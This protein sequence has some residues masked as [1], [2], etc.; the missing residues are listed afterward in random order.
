MDKTTKTKKDSTAAPKTIS[1][2][3]TTTTKPTLVPKSKTLDERSSNSARR[4]YRTREEQRTTSRAVQSGETLETIDSALKLLKS[5][6]YKKN[7]DQSIDL[8][9]TFK[10]L[11][12]NKP[13]NNIKLLLNLPE[14]KKKSRIAL[15]VK[16]ELLDSAKKTGAQIILEDELLKSDKKK[17]KKYARQTDFFLVHLPLMPIFAKS[18]GQFVAKRGKMP[19]PKLQMVFSDQTNLQDLVNRF[20]TSTKLEF[21]KQPT[22]QCSIGSESQDDKTLL[23]NIKKVL[24]EL[25]TKINLKNHLRQVMLKKTMTAPIKVQI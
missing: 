23:Q 2:Q 19:D 22:L 15:V 25:G 7:F 5:D 17:I 16:K 13:E 12:L 10:D 1:T 20:S 8:I 4:I 11:D 3:S 6:Q 9:L 18:F 24:E 14:K 21:K